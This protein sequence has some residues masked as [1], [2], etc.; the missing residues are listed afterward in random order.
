MANI[1][2]PK[3]KTAKIRREKKKLLL[4]EPEAVI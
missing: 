4:V 1:K 2:L 3:L